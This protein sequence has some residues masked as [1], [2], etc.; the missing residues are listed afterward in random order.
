MVREIE[1]KYLL[2]NSDWQKEADDGTVIK[3]GYLN[4]D[5]ERTVRVR[6]IGKK[7]I[8]TIKSK[9][10]GITRNEFEYEIPYSDTLA[11]L[12]LCAPP[13]IEKIRYKI[14]R[15]H[16]VWEIDIFSGENEGLAIAEVELSDENQTIHLPSWL[17]K[18]VS[19]EVK[20]Y[21]SNLVLHPFKD[22]GK[23]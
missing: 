17:G 18:E 13:L 3:Q 2:K 9:N 1:R 10:I 4:T 14:N 7:G 22:W 21:N 6:L 23:E 12:K 16:L 8:L 19:S 5:P 15:D 11:L 20:Y